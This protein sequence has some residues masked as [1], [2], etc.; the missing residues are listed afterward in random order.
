MSRHHHPKQ[1]GRMGCPL[2]NCACTRSEDG[3]RCRQCTFDNHCG[4]HDDGC[5]RS[6]AGVHGPPRIGFRRFEGYRPEEPE[7]DQIGAMKPGRPRFEGVVFSDGTTVLRWCGEIHSTSVFQSFPA[8]MKAHG[9]PEYG[10]VIKWLDE[11]PD[12]PH[13]P[14]VAA[15]WP[16]GR[17][18]DGS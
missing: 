18:A 14:A 17:N 13:A 12:K 4:S 6:C 2:Y 9:H 3:T 11:V 5:H 1:S 7:R 8:M 15:Y 10:T 16:L